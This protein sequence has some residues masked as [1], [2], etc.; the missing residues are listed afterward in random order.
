MLCCFG[1]NKKNKG[2]VWFAVIALG[3]I[4]ALGYTFHWPI[5][6]NYWWILILLLC[7]IM[8]LT[9][10]GHEGEQKGRGG[11]GGHGQRGENKR[12]HDRHGC[13]H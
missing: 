11:Y 9:M 3:A 4:V 5:V 13:C 1:K 8:H 2:V 12:P 7:P 6:T 10:M